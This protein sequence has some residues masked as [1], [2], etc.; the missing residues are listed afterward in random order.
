MNKVNGH[1]KLK[2]AEKGNIRRKVLTY[3]LVFLLVVLA[4][5]YF[6][7]KPVLR[8]VLKQQLTAITGSEVDLGKVSQRGGGVDLQNLTLRL[9][10]VAGEAGE[11]ITLKRGYVGLNVSSYFPPRFRIHDIH[12]SGARLRIMQSSKDGSLPLAAYF[13]ELFKNSSSGSNLT[14][15]TITM[16]GSAIEYGS[17][18][19]S[20]KITLLRRL[21]V[22]GRLAADRK[23]P[24]NYQVNLQE[25]KPGNADSGSGAVGMKVTGSFSPTNGS[26]NLTLTQSFA[27]D[28]WTEFILPAR[29]RKWW[30]QVM[31][32]GGVDKASLHFDPEG[33]VAQVGLED[34]DL[35]LRL[36]LGYEDEGGEEETPLQIRGARGEL[37][38][39]RDG[40]TFR[41]LRLNV[42]GMPCTVTGMYGGYS[43]D[44]SLNL[45]MQFDPFSVERL[46]NVLPLM[47]PDVRAELDEFKFKEAWLTGDIT[48]TR[49][50]PIDNTAPQISV[51]ADFSAKN[52]VGHTTYFPYPILDG[53]GRITFADG[54]LCIQLDGS[55]PSGAAIGL[56]ASVLP[57]PVNSEVDVEITATGVPG[58]EYLR[59]ALWEDSSRVLAEFLDQSSYDRLHNAGLFLSQA[60]YS[61]ILKQKRDLLGK[62]HD[63]ENI[64]ESD[65]LLLSKI[66]DK[67]TRPVF[68][69]GILADVKVIVRRSEESGGDF[70]HRI[71]IQLR[72]GNLIYRHFP[73]PIVVKSGLIVVTDEQADL[74]LDDLRLPDGSPL[75]EVTG[76]ILLEKGGKEVYEPDI[77]VNVR[78]VKMNDFLSYA[79][80]SDEEECNR[81]G[82][83]PSVAGRLL[84]DLKLRGKIS[85]VAR[86]TVDEIGKVGY[87]VVCMFRDGTVGSSESKYPLTDVSGDL[88]ISSEGVRITRVEA[89]HKDTVIQASGFIT[90][91]NKEK[92]NNSSEKNSQ[93]QYAD[94]LQGNLNLHLAELHLEEQFGALF[95]PFIDS[96]L[97]SGKT[98]SQFQ[99]LIEKYNPSG[100]ADAQI[101]ITAPGDGSATYNASISVIDPDFTYDG[102]RMKYMGKADGITATSEYIQFDDTTI[103]LMDGG[104]TVADIILNGLWHRTG[105]REDKDSISFSGNSDLSAGIHLKG[106]NVHL[107]SEVIRS[108]V[109]GFSGLKLAEIIERYS[110]AGKVDIGLYAKQNRNRATISEVVIKPR[111]LKV[112]FD[113]K[114]SNSSALELTDI[115]GDI[116]Y[117]KGVLSINDMQGKHTDGTFFLSGT[118]SYPVLQYVEGLETSDT[119]DGTDADLSFDFETSNWDSKI[120]SLFSDSLAIMVKN[121]KIGRD[122]YLRV[123]DGNL[124]YVDRGDDTQ[125]RITVSA[126]MALKDA[127]FEAGLPVDGLSGDFRVLFDK[128]GWAENPEVDIQAS[129]LNGRFS[130]I[131]VSEL[132]LRLASGDENGEYIIPVVMGHVHGGDLS[133]KG[134][135]VISG[136]TQY[137][138]R[139]IASEVDL[140]PLL[141]ELHEK[142][143]AE[144][145]QKTE[146]VLADN[147]SVSGLSGKVYLVMGISGVAGV[148]DSL[149]G[150]GSARLAGDAVVQ[151]PVVMPLVQLGNFIPPH[152][153]PF[154]LAE[155]EFHLKGDDLHFDRV[156]LY[157]KSVWIGGRGDVDLDD[158]SVDFVF[159]SE[160]LQ[161]DM[162]P[163]SQLLT[164]V[165]DEIISIKVAGL[166]Y[167]PT[168]QPMSLTGTRRTLAEIFG[169]GHKSESRRSP[170]TKYRK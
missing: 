102:M 126:E 138:F 170:R 27:F 93:E 104:Q 118:V 145:V 121:F 159:T 11:L 115:S 50:K 71:S 79:I 47:P 114:E 161:P 116:E 123:H 6:A 16:S 135:F 96:G 163:F 109:A 42:L 12:L 10:G 30:S 122:G 43:K 83:P 101:E 82:E 143:P 70:Q 20:G 59:K 85:A 61:D 103:S 26:G 133:G 130:G 158:L 148:Q 136:S 22:S 46:E 132:Q 157:S 23:N 120:E 162:G 127:G 129:H 7:R 48:L 54:R 106:F 65:R 53:N 31:V 150:N 141:K 112:G 84:H 81:T 168:F 3:L 5:F 57:K 111:L 147:E 119:A 67:L 72:D 51:Y 32:Q 28:D 113:N 95:E 58:D 137:E 73:Y 45:K 94:I 52:V 149:V 68:D 55:G 165:R 92:S 18:D 110:L 9:P 69:L 62:Y 99:E 88:V 146:L 153:D 160:G 66:N 15:P 100:T 17:Y 29:I 2:R 87:Q 166:L 40:V 56:S 24:E 4:G 14:L 154:D 140:Q 107:E 60:E 77:V 108:L 74:E 35:D 139:L 156:G 41:D 1:K 90:T 152:D 21:V 131:S 97:I 169:S 39:D 25:I 8:L 98:L 151:L 164:G 142:Y 117:R 19:D 78:S 36:P 76:R 33:V 86:I 89:K 91:T 63:P 134:R 34:V 44:S 167:D 37:H 80:P 124:R 155:L 49:D 125:D 64:S 38:F 13:T 75:G 128:R 144:E 105:K